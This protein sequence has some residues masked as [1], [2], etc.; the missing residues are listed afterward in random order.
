MACLDPADGGTHWKQPLTTKKAHFT[1]TP[2]VMVTRT[3]SGDRRQLFV[4]GAI[5]EVGVGR[6][7][8]FCLEDFLKVE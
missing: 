2:R 6:P 4:A 3:E 1:A 7:I 5:G 8:V